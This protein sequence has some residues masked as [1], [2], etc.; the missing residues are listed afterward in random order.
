M[1]IQEYALAVGHN[2]A[3]GLFNVEDF[4]YDRGS[5]PRRITLTADPV[6][7]GALELV[8]LDQKLHVDGTPAVEWQHAAIPVTALDALI[9]RLFGNY[10]TDNASVTLRTRQRD[11]T[12]ANYN[13]ELALPRD[14]R[15]RRATS[16]QEIALDVTWRFRIIEAL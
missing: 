6:P 3:A 4:L 1:P 5:R 12:F 14:Y 15:I 11:S 7:P 13:A 8:T 9:I 2:N 16:G 10:D